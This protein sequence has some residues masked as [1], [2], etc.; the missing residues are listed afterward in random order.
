MAQAKVPPQESLV[1][2]KV[3][4]IERTL[5]QRSFVSRSNETPSDLRA[6]WHSHPEFHG[7]DRNAHCLPNASD[8][9]SK[10]QLFWEIFTPIEYASTIRRA[11]G[12]LRGPSLGIHLRGTDKVTEILPP[13]L[14]L[15]RRTVALLVKKHQIESIFLATDDMKYRR[16]LIRWFGEK[17][18][19]LDHQVSKDGLPIH[20]SGNRQFLDREVLNDIIVLTQCDHFIYSFSNVSHLALIMR[21]RDRQNFYNIASRPRLTGRLRY[22]SASYFGFVYSMVKIKTFGKRRT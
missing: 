1:K 5:E 10:S 12:L 4:A 8:L 7:T 14:R 3:P 22:F 11:K 17:V 6:F 16:K 20:L 18:V 19:F 2:I 15:I 9:E 21:Y 13:S